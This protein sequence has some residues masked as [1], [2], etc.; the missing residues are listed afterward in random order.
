MLAEAIEN[1]LKNGRVVT[2]EMLLKG[3]GE[4]TPK[5]KAKRE[6]PGDAGLFCGGGW[7]GA[8][9]VHEFF[10]VDDLP[11]S[12]GRWS[13]A[14]VVMVAAAGRRQLKGSTANVVWVGKRCWPTFQFLC[15]AM[16]EEA[17]RRSVFLDPLTDE[18]RFWAI[19]QA[20]RCP[21]VKLVIAD[22]SG[23]N[24]T[25]SRRLQLAAERGEENG[26][27]DAEEGVLGLLARPAWE[28][29]T[30]SWARGRWIIRPVVAE[31]G[32]VMRWEVSSCR[33]QSA[34]QDAPPEW[35]VEW[36][37][38]DYSRNRLGQNSGMSHDNGV[39]HAAR[40]FHIFA[41][42]GRGVDPAALA[43]GRRTA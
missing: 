41:G 31:T 4:N 6:G 42:V 10:L 15:G 13:A 24:E 8:G 14:L 39:S 28:I 7:E 30:S 25:V 18:D 21:G 12:G 9:E 23:M 26:E 2:G 11:T 1:L 5:L 37:Y 17:L 33:G 19:G 27:G 36:R 40:A 35:M 3:A 22:G 16:G 38:D 43:E 34:G 29:E 20:L 32:D